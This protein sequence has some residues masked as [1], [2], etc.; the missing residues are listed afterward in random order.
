MSTGID[1][2][3]QMNMYD[4]IIAREQANP[5][6]NRMALEDELALGM[7]MNRLIN[8]SHPTLRGLPRLELGYQ[9]LDILRAQVRLNRKLQD[10]LSQEWKAYEPAPTLSAGMSPDSS[11][12][13]QAAV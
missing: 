6:P 2:E 10:L 7:E 9:V 1:E 13:D 11:D 4:E 12:L 3:T 5:K 8:A